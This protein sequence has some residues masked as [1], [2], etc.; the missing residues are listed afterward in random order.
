M[1]NVLTLLKQAFK[2]W[3]EEE[4]FR[5]SAVIAYYAIF[6]LPALLIIVI[7]VAGAVFGEQ[8]VSDEVFV[9][10]NEMMGADAAENVRNMIGR[11]SE[12]KPSLIGNIIG[13]GTLLFGAT[14]VFYQLQISLNQIW[15]V[16]SNPKSGFLDFLM[17]RALSLGMILVIGLL[18]LITLV[19]STA[20]SVLSE[21]IKSIIPDVFLYLSFALNFLISFG[22]IAVLFA[23]IFKV[24]PDVKIRWRTV[25]TGAFVTAFLFV[26]GKFGLSFYFGESDPASVYGAAGTIILILLW[27]YYSC[28]ILFFGASFTFVYAQF[29]HLPVEPSKYAVKVK[30]IK[31]TQK[32]KEPRDPVND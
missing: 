15:N 1:K 18:L 17:K 10:I 21:W 11:A 30:R 14:G 6:S 12:T 20:L 13:I 3:N 2:K 24:M 9:Q 31:V 5:L 28:L 8:N 25:W 29:K 32:P 26:V 19:V 7:N 23:L 16:E 22:I 27:V 4:P